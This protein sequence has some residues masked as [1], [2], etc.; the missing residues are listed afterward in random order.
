MMWRSQTAASRAQADAFPIGLAYVTEPKWGPK[1]TV[2]ALMALASNGHTSSS[3]Y[4]VPHPLR[5]MGHE[6]ADAAKPRVGML[7]PRSHKTE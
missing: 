7:R 4:S 6:V 1:R 3:H 5:Q 2:V